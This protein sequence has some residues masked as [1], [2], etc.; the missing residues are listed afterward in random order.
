MND[1]FEITK[2]FKNSQGDQLILKPSQLELFYNIATRRYPRNSILCHTR[3][4][5]SMTIA[6]GILSRVINYPEKWVIIGPTRLQADVIMKH[7]IQHLFDDK[8]FFSQLEVDMPLERIK[9]ERKKDRMTFRRGGEVFILT[10]DVSNTKRLGSVLGQGSP[11]V[12][13]DEAPLV[14]DKIEAMVSRML[15]DSADNFYLKIGNAFENN[16]FKRTFG[17]P[18]W[19]N[20]IVDCY[21]GLKEAEGLP[22]SEGHLT[23]EIINEASYRPF[24]EQLWECKFPDTSLTDER[25]YT[26]IVTEKELQEAF[27]RA[28]KKDGEVICGNDVGAG[29]DFS[30]H[31]ARW[32]KY[33]EKLN[34]NKDRDT[35][36]QIQWI[37]KFREELKVGDIFPE[38]VI[39]KIGIGTG[40][41]DRCGELDIPVVGFVAGGK[42]QENERFTNLKSEAYWNL[43]QWI[44]DGGAIKYDKQ[45]LEQLPEIR[46]KEDSE[47]RVKIEPKQDYVK[48]MGF[49]PDDAEALMLTFA[50]HEPEP[51][52]FII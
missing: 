20:I 28:E 42:A 15:A 46:Y 38:Y 39:D 30:V 47:R 27:N 51:D 32:S 6:L 11:N 1:I 44:K 17:D 52:I 48:R 10:A 33:A 9:R 12:V 34:R 26:P 24:F 25:G 41:C 22:Y 23:Q 43:R 7:F 5:K 37:Q 2:Y 21:N 13:L 40:L 16:H 45:L 8:R 18:D 29:G 36:G 19:N 4:G 35:M 14:P 3:F 31:Y 49:S 50:P